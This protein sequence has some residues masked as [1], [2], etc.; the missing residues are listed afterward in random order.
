MI[1]MDVDINVQCRDWDG[2]DGL[3]ALIGAAAQA[4]AEAAGPAAGEARRLEVSVM[5]TSDEEIAALNAAY[6]QRDGATNVLSFPQA[7]PGGTGGGADGPARL[8]GDIVLA[9]ETISREAREAGKSMRDHISHLVVHGMLHLFGYDHEED[10]E[11]EVMEGLETRILAGLGIADPYGR[12]AE[13]ASLGAA[14]SGK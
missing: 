4:A 11:A 1:E 6:R 5:L 12:A 8:I 13:S 7:M 9:H 10:T 3:D 2:L 14:G